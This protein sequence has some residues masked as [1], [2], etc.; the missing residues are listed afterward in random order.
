MELWA[1]L[2]DI[3]ANYEA[4]RAVVAD[5]ERIAEQERAD[6][7]RYVCLGDVVDY[8][9][10]PNECMDWVTRNVSLTVLGNHDEDVAAPFCTPP[11]NVGQRW[12][13][14][15][16]WT[17]RVLH[18]EHKAKVK[19]WPGVLDSIRGLDSFALWHGGL[20]PDRYAYITNSY[21]AWLT[22][23][24]LQDDIPYGIFGHTHMQG[25][26]EENRFKYGDRRT[27]TMYL[28][29]NTGSQSR[30][31]TGWYPASPNQWRDMPVGRA[32]FNPGSVG[33]PRPH[34]ALRGRGTDDN[35]AAY[36]LLRCNG[37]RQFQF[38]RVKYD[39]DKTIKQMERIRWPD[40]EIQIGH[41]IYKSVQDAVRA[42]RDAKPLGPEKQALYEV[43]EDID[44]RLQ[45]IVK[46]L[47]SWLR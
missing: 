22:I 6:D 32:I 47:I 4:L 41:D 7:L 33:Q 10:Q 31:T 18:C 14:I 45:A 19:A 43:L 37:H 23:Q 8:G 5:A 38:R 28:A 34:A 35:R 27:T 9:P 16:L 39:L 11:H 25:Y 13:P 24:E 30:Y 44:E 26:F 20:E 17:R 1:V 46:R 3:H 42:S 12:W 36:M 29:C 15:T 21:R 2:S 40:G